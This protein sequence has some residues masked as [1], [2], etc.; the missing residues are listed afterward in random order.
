MSPLLK[1]TPENFCLSSII[2]TQVMTVYKN[3]DAH[4]E[5]VGNSALALRLTL[6]GGHTTMPLDIDVS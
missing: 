5:K 2:Q 3:D 6:L 4:R 1:S